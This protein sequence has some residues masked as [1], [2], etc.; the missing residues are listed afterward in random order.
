MGFPLHLTTLEFSL[1][2]YIEIEPSL[3]FFQAERPLALYLYEN[4]KELLLTLI[5]GRFIHSAVFAANSSTM[6]MLE[7]D[8]KKE[9]NL[10]SSGNLILE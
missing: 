8:L 3:N 10:I 5:M 4:L 9:K 1:F 6:K 7:I 2:R